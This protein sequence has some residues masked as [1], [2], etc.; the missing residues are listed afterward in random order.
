MTTPTSVP[1]SEPAPPSLGGKGAG[2]LG[3]HL[4]P[5]D[6][7]PGFVP[8][9]KAAYVETMFDTIAPRYDLMN[10]L[11]T[12]GMDRGWRQYVVA[13]AAPP[14]GGNT[15]DVAT[16]TG[17]IAIALAQCI[18]PRGTV[19][20]T[21]FSEAMMRPGPGKAT[22][23]GVGGIVRFMAADALGLP[24]PDDTFDCVTT[25]FAMRNVTDI[26]R[27]FREMRRVAKPGG[28]VVCLEV[29]KPRFPPVRFLHQHYFNWIVPLLGRIVTGHGEAYRYLPESARNFP[30]P[31]ALKTIMEN[32]GLRDVHFRRLSLGA[33]AVHTGTK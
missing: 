16:G 29:A 2:G 12:F 20:A 6:N 3:N 18:G 22:K 21:D 23:A 8:E 10:R 28:R 11:M 1:N 7:L 24:F 9:R 14:V 27:A 19:L 25:G 30:P 15:L 4:I 32:A 17:D 5:T 26:E 31:P 33:V 13:Q